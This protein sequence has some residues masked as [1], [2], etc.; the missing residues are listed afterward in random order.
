MRPEDEGAYLALREAFIWTYS[1]G[2]TR[3]QQTVSWALDATRRA[4]NMATP[5]YCQQASNVPDESTVFVG[6]EVHLA[7]PDG[8]CKR[9]LVIGDKEN[10]AAQGRDGFR[11][12]ELGDEQAT[13]EGADP[14]TGRIAMLYLDVLQAFHQPA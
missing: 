8:T 4:F 6:A 12:L 7:A 14:F 3:P 5:N 9:W 1:S 11:A 13:P 10:N 2:Q